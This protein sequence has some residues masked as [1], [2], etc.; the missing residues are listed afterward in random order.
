MRHRFHHHLHKHD[1]FDCEAEELYISLRGQELACLIIT[2]DM[3]TISI[4]VDDNAADLAPLVQA[5]ADAST[6]V[7]TALTALKTASDALAAFQIT[8]TASVGPE[9]PEAPAA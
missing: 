6:A 7:E 5:V 3:A 9:A 2:K 1:G 8:F 4:E